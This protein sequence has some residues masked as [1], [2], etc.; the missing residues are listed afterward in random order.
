MCVHVNVYC[1]GLYSEMYIINHMKYKSLVNKW[2]V[3]F[4]LQI[5]HHVASCACKADILNLTYSFDNISK[6]MSSCI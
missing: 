5:L 3:F 4:S 1:V 2:H 6:S